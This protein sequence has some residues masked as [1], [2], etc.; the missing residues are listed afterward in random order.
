MVYKTAA[1]L[2]YGEKA[3]I[4]E[5]ENHRLTCKLMEMGC[6]QGNQISLQFKSPLGDP[7]AFEIA[8]YRLGLRKEEAGLLKVEVIP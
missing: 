7:L 3:I 8:G 6:Q 4:R 1:Q 2:Q 5:I